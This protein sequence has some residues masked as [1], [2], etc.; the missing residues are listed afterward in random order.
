MPSSPAV[1]TLTTL[2]AD[3]VEVPSLVVVVSPPKGRDLE[4]P[5]AVAPLVLGS[6][7]ECDLVLVDPRVSR[8]HCEVVLTERGVLLRDLGSKNGSFIGDVPIVEAFLPPGKKATIGG[9][10]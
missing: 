4:A 6:S 1:P 2:R 8:R 3:A 10:T 5:L 7:P 9:S